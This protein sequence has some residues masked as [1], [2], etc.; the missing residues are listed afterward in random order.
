MYTNIIIIF[1]NNSLLL[2][3]FD[4]LMVVSKMSCWFFVS[5]TS[6]HICCVT[7]PTKITVRIFLETEILII[8]FNIA[9]GKG[10]NKKPMHH[11]VH[12]N[13]TT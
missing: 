13:I 12:Q 4:Y 2:F 9:V 3:F 11:N 5:F 8:Y 6:Q 10:I 1:D 7:Q